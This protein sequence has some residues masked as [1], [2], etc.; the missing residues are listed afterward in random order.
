[1]EASYIALAIAPFEAIIGLA[2]S[3]IGPLILYNLILTVMP[4]IIGVGLLRERVPQMIRPFIILIILGFLKILSILLNMEPY[5]SGVID[6]GIIIASCSIPMLLTIN[7]I[8][9]STAILSI[10]G[11]IMVLF[12]SPGLLGIGLILW[13]LS[14]LLAASFFKDFI[15]ES[16][17]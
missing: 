12:R 8:T 2:Y 10:I 7:K 17:D 4:F 9:S 15:R 14:L 3:N 5:I 11:S 6:A 1:M 13:G 16:K